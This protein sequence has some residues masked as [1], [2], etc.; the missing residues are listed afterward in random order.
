MFVKDEFTASS[1][2]GGVKWRVV[3]VGKLVFES[4]EQEFSL[5]GVKSKKISSHPG[6]D[7][8]KSVLKVRNAWVKVKW[9]KREEKLS[10]ICVKV[11]VEGKKK[12]KSAERFGVHDEE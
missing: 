10:I 5:R 8:L 6:K 3:Y 9:V 7:V 12:D 4:D 2:V 1:R 11:V